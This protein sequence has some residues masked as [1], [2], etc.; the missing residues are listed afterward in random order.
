[1]FK[2]AVCDD[3]QRYLHDVNRLL[4]EYGAAHGIELVAA[5]FS[6]PFDLSERVTL[7][8]AALYLV[9][10]GVCFAVKDPVI[11]GVDAINTLISLLLGVSIARMMIRDRLECFE[12]SRL[13]K[14]EQETD[15][16]TTLSNR[17]KLFDTMAAI[18]SGNEMPPET[19]ACVASAPC[20]MNLRRCI[21]SIFTATAARNLLHLSGI[22]I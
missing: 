5:A 18:E 15:A 12:A 11:A 19:S 8:T 17:R 4:D 6:L 20:S 10:T 7:Y 13:L 3:E 22:V 16:L 2:I 21:K 1:M 14:Q 9:H